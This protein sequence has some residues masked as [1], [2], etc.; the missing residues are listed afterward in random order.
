MHLEHVNSD[1]LL[2]GTPIGDIQVVSWGRHH[3][4]EATDA[5]GRKR[6][7]SQWDGHM[8]PLDAIIGTQMREQLAVRRLCERQ[9][10][11]YLESA[12][13]RVDDRA[14]YFGREVQRI[15]DHGS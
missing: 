12:E 15:V 2:K 4:I 9:K 14:A 7:V 1:P 10:Q 6:L 5:F 8:H 3:C 13:A 11:A